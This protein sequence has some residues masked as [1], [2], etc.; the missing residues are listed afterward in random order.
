MRADHADFP[1]ARGAAGAVRG[2]LHNADDRDPIIIAHRIERDRA[3][4][5]AGD[6]QRFAV[7]LL[8]KAGVIYG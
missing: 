8:Q 3:R 2:R 4:R 6:H 7:K 1:V 5:A